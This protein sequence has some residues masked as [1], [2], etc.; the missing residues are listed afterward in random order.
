MAIRSI[1]RRTFLQGIGTLVALPA[2]ESFG[3]PRLRTGATSVMDTAPT[4]MV[5]CYVPN[6]V[7]MPSWK[8]E[9][10][11]SDYVMT[12]TLAPL[13]SHRNNISILSG[14]AQNNARPLGDGGG[15]H[16]RGAAVFLTGEHPVKTNGK[17][18]KAG[19]SVDQIA[20][21]HLGANTRFAS[22]EL[23]CEPGRLAGSCDSGYGCA[24][25]HTLSWK[26]PIQPLQKET[27]PALVFD[28]LFGG[29]SDR[30]R[31]YSLERRNQ[32]KQSILDFVN[33]DARDL[34]RILAKSDKLKIEQ[35]LDSIRD[36]ERRIQNPEIAFQSAGNIKR[37]NGRPAL[38]GERFRLMADLMAIALKVDATRV[39]TFMVANEGSNYPYRELGHTEGH[40]SLS[41][42]RGRADLISQIEEINLHH[43]QQ[44]EYLLDKLAEPDEKDECLLDST[45][46]VYGSGISDGNRHNHDDLPILVAGKGN[47]LFSPGRH[48]EFKKNTPLM[49]LY[50]SMLQ[51]A[52]IE[53]DRVG[54]STG[55][56]EGLSM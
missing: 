7:H 42:H 51:G 29:G 52:G 12:S 25:S 27:N 44:L 31:Q 3:A 8:P 15:D 4:R 28:R 9:S 34:S 56:L 6:G 46:L 23:G 38:L 48:I 33:D 39:I 18:M 30:D 1:G 35:Y 11:G 14:L 53:I 50:L 20:A 49:N 10:S 5:F 19:I 37:P 40:H 24:Y 55:R 13:E 2:L 36:V 26:S 16:A 17:D 45:M 32:A 54:D 41:H 21:K 47:G 22:L 43:I